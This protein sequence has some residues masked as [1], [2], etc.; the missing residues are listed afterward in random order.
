MARQFIV[1]DTETTGLTRAE[2][3]LTLP[4]T[5][6]NRGD[7]VCQIGGLILNERMEPTRLFCHYCDTVTVECS[8]GA[9]RV[10]GMTMKE[11]R[12]YVRCQYLPVV[13]H[14][15]VPEFFWND[16]IF[17]GY[18][19]EFD[20]CMVKQTLSNTGVDFKWEPFKGSILPKTGRHAVDVA[21]YFK[22]VSSGGSVSTYKK[23]ASYF[24]KLSSFDAELEPARQLFYSQYGD[25][26]V[27][28]NCPELFEP[29]WCKAHSAFYDALNTFLLWRDYVWHKKVV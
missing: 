27:E 12:Q 25:L 24:R 7:E 10:H 3:D 18:N 21:E 14:D 13:L 16:I 5:L 17:I 1:Y 26:Q 20:Q 23:H 28:S 19:V 29:S 2:V 15:N 4:A 22:R 6:H 9:T 8:P 11:I